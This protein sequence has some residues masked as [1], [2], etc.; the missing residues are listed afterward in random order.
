MKFEQ[1][2]YVRPSIEQFTEQFNSL[3]TAFEQADSFESQSDIFEQINNMR[4]E[5]SSMYN[6]CHIRH[7]IN[8]KDEFYDSLR[9]GPDPCTRRFYS[10]IVHWRTRKHGSL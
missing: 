4:T 1:F 6:I 7:T 10:M 8:T 2:Q 5:F 3:L 9:S